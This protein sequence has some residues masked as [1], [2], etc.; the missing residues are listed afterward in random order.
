MPV[1]GEPSRG[2]SPPGLA[3]R[4][5]LRPVEKPRLVRP[6]GPVDVAPLQAHVARYEDLP[7]DPHAGF[8]AVVRFAGRA[9]TAGGPGTASPRT[10]SQPWNTS[11]RPVNRTV[12]YSRPSVSS[13]R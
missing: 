7:A 10:S 8:G 5:G 11:A 3:E 2:E 12:G 13:D 6:L 4:S 9:G 1:P